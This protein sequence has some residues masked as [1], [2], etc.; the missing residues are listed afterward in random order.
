MALLSHVQ[1]GEVIRA[2]AWNGLVDQVNTLL[3]GG[4]TV[5][6]VPVPS[7]IGRP[8]NQA[9]ALLTQPSVNLALGVTLD[10][11]G[12]SVDPNA[13]ASQTRTVI[14]Q[15]PSAGVQAAV[16]SPVD[17][18]LAALGSPSTQ[19][20]PVILGTS[21]PSTPIGQ[22]LTIIGDNFDLTA[23]KNIVTFDGVSAGVPSPA[24]KTSLTVTVPTVPGVPKTVQ[25]VVSIVGG[26]SSGPFST[27]IT[28]ALPGATPTIASVDVTPN[29]I[30]RVG[31]SIKIT[32]TNF[33]ATANQNT[34]IF[35]NVQVAASG[36][37]G[38]T[39]LT[40]T[41]PDIPGVNLNG[42]PKAVALR[43]K[44]GAQTSQTPAAPFFVEKV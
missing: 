14:M 2:S 13:P 34:V 15:S 36:A 39:Q 6:G 10:A 18:V 22:P 32:G 27:T 42:P 20:A 8:L 30:A 26:P 41:V 44:V 31:Q 1:P 19:P 25:V 16:G 43:V 5:A 33:N 9:R 7:V 12:T 40:V 11:F 29:A 38:T 17:L 4:G 21:A 28:T 24:S 37:T 23:N 35:D 3:G